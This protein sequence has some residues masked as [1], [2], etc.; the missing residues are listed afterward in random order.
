MLNWQYS[1]LGSTNLPSTMSSPSGLSDAEV[2]ALCQDPDADTKDFIVQ[3]IMFHMKDPRK[4]LPFYTK[5]L[6]M[7]L[8]QKLDL[9]EYR[10]SAYFV[11][12]ENESEIPSGDKERTEWTLSRKATLELIHNWGTENNP[13]LKYNDS[14]DQFNGFGHIG[15]NV[16]DVDA[17]CA[18]F[19][20]LGVSFKKRPEDGRTKG[21]AFIKD[22]DGN[23]IEILNATAM[24][25][26][27]H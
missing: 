10:L 4:S 1:A 21:V 5:V 13:D 19:E 20:K 18:R 12:Y 14:K 27:L 16:P 8:L 2:K 26:V 24:A 15:L 9:P 3:Q 17:A 6:G 23:E 11:G 25:E 7:R 22:P